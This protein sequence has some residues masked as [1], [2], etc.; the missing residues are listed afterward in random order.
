MYEPTTKPDGAT[1][2]SGCPDTEKG[3]PNV[4]LTNLMKQVFPTE[5][6]ALKLIHEAMSLQETER[7]RVEAMD[8]LNKAQDLVP[9]LFRVHFARAEVLQAS[10]RLAEALAEARLGLQ[11][12]PFLECPHV[13]L[14]AAE[15]L[16]AQGQVEEAL[17]HFY[18]FVHLSSMAPLDDLM[19]V[20]SAAARRKVDISPAAVAA[21]VMALCS[22]TQDAFIGNLEREHQKV[23]EAAQQGEEFEEKMQCTLCYGTL[24][25]PLTTPC[26]HSFCQICLLRTLDHQDACPLCRSSLR[27]Y[28]ASHEYKVT[29]ALDSFLEEYQ[30]VGYEE[31]REQ[32]GREET[33]FNANLPLFICTLAFPGVH[34]PLHIF[35]PRYRLMIRRC[36]ES[37]RK[38]FGMC[39]YSE[40][41]GYAE[42]GTAL[43]IREYRILPDGRS[44]VN[45]IGTRRFRVLESSVRDGYTV[46]RVE[47]FDDAP[48][49]E[50]QVA[51]VQRLANELR[52]KIRRLR[53][54]IEAQEP[55]PALLSWLA[56]SVLP[57][58]GDQKYSFL[59]STNLLERLQTL[60]NLCTTVTHALGGQ[61]DVM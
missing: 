33:E 3:V 17:S 42:Y 22:M 4:V 9:G 31:R 50:D 18:A 54:S 30:R 53:P 12:S 55:D 25:Q 20:F 11:A 58:A 8:R 61:C 10:G 26:G 24:Y 1:V 36:F 51:E 21:R 49:P 23:L 56:L 35:E 34:C 27:Q 37:P 46:G 13:F 32:A 45:T 60:S 6:S 44:L 5:Y 39:I 28:L 2:C 15:I 47:Y 29:Q 48:V 7:D 40:E 14:K 41:G 52:E 57:I 59:S 19:A 16:A 43:H 38:Q